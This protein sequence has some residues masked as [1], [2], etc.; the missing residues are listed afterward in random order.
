MTV[1][2]IVLAFIAGIVAGSLVNAALVTLGPRLIP[3]P[4]GV[5]P[6]D[7]ESFK[8]AAHLMSPRHFV[9]P[10]LAHALGTFAGALVAWL[11]APRSRQRVA[12]L[13]GIF[14]LCGGIAASLMIPAPKGFIALD[15]LLAYLPMAWLAAR[16]GAAV[17]G[18]GAARS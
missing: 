2:K 17:K 9:F 1:L 12:W 15:L 4:E 11:L 3:L 16:L 6:A 10:F 14:F 8:A 7:M 13:I 18:E 5:N